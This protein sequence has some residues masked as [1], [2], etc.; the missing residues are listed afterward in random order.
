MQLIH[1]NPARPRRVLWLIVIFLSAMAVAQNNPVPLVYQPLIPATVEPGH[2]AFTLTVNGTGFATDAVLNWNGS[3]RLTEVDSDH[4]LRATIEAKDVAKIGTASITVTNPPP[5]GGTS[6]VVFLPI[7]KPSSFVIFT[8]IADFPPAPVNAVGDFNND[9]KLDIAVGLT[10][11]DGSGEIDIYLGNGDGTFRPSVKTKTVVAD[12][13]MLAADFNGDGK[14]DLAVLDGLGTL[15]VYLGKGNGKMVQQQ[16]FDTPGGSL[17][18]ADFNRDGKLDLLATGGNYGDVYLGNGD[19]TFGSPI[20]IPVPYYGIGNVGIGDFNG[21]GYLDLADSAGG[22]YILLGNGDGTFQSGIPYKT[23]YGGYSAAAADVNGDGNLDVVTSGFEVMLGNG[24]G[25]FTSDGG[26]NLGY[27]YSG[28]EVAIGDFNGDGKLDAALIQP[29]A[30]SYN[31][32]FFQ[33]NGDGTFQSPIAF[34]AANNPYSLNM[35][36]FNGDGRLDLVG[37]NLF[38]QTSVMLAP[39]SLAFGIENVGSQSPPQTATLTNDG[40]SALKIKQIG[41]N[42]ADPKDFG[43]TNNCGTSVPAGGSCQIQVTFT[44]TA[45]GARSASL[46]VDYQGLGSPQ[47]V[48]LSGTGANLTVTLTPSS[49]T[50]PVQVVGTTSSEQTATLTNT[51]SDAVTISNISTSGPF[52]QTNNCPSSLY[53]NNSCQIQVKFTPT[54]K[55]PASGTLS[56]TD[57]AQGSPQTVNLSGTGTVVELSTVGINFG[58][59]KVGTKSPPAPIKLTNVGTASLS[60]SQIAIT[61]ADAEDFSQSDNCGHS[62]PPKGSCKITVIFKPTAKGERA[63]RLGISDNGG[64]SP[65]MVSLAGTGT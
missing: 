27:Y 55:G 37:G 52:S 48:A 6:N 2:K 34:P 7:R 28:A 59:Q 5:G 21:D 47:T 19:G 39:S 26:F 33:G 41:I 24:D 22:L 58:D 32:D 54:A 15:T 31:I 63:A 16:V 12:A 51:G 45:T 62:V 36:D 44:P 25:A 43:Q 9:G 57:A 46:F 65:Q 14:L 30:S 8:P 61:G 56:V 3:T 4:Q 23:S 50:F 53:P 18:A 64:A 35:G 1:D 11:S 42:G 20:S 49:M 10:N 38:L 29:N 40:S 13:V 17:K 60:I